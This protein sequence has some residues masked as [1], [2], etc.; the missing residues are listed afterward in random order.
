LAIDP[1]TPPVSCINE[2]INNYMFCG[3]ELTQEQKQAAYNAYIE[4]TK[5]KPFDY[6]S[7]IN[8]LE[9]QW[10][11]TANI[12]AFYIF[13]PI[14]V[15]LLTAIWL[16]V[17]FKKMNWIVGIYLSI[18][19]IVVLYGFNLA[20]RINS[21]YYYQNKFQNLKNEA[22]QTTQ[23]Y[24]NSIA[25]QTQGLMAAACAVTCK[26]GVN[27]WKCNGTTPCPPCNANNQ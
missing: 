19:V 14:L 25:L 16:Y 1:T 13:V 17:G 26:D 12:I 15:L 20:Y 6:Q 22:A 23:S 2:L 7:F 21:Q 5:L 10:V 24:Q 11:A 3:Q 8:N 9:A 27:C 4:V 18:L